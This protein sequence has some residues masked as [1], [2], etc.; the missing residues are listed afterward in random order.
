ME[1]TGIKKGS[2]RDYRVVSARGGHGMRGVGAF[3]TNFQLACEQL[4]LV[5]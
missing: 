3:L 4:R 1:T 2:Y 5:P